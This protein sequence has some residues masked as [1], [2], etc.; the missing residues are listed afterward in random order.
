MSETETETALFLDGRNFNE[1]TRR[2]CFTYN[3]NLLS[4]VVVLIGLKGFSILLWMR[5]TQKAVSDSYLEFEAFPGLPCSNATLTF[6]LTVTNSNGH[7]KPAT[8]PHIY[9]DYDD[10]FLNF[11]LNIAQR[12]W[13]EPFPRTC[14]IHYL[15]SN[16]I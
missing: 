7:T 9:H 15:V 4:L 8:L 6:G 2:T 11:N 3:K 13:R 16:V 1:K 5:P 14:H 12:Y 10:D